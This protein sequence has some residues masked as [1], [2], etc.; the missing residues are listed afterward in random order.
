MVIWEMLERES[1]VSRIYGG[2]KTNG[3]HVKCTSEFIEGPLL[4]AGCIFVI[5][6]VELEKPGFR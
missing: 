6:L 5:P 3:T 4:Y 1:S 2:P